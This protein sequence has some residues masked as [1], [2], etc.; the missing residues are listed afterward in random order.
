MQRFAGV[1]MRIE[2]VAF[3]SMATL[4][5]HGKKRNEQHDGSTIAIRSTMNKEGGMTETLTAA[6]VHELS[7]ALDPQHQG[8]QWPD[9]IAWDGRSLKEQ[10]EDLL[11]LADVA[12]DEQLLPANSRIDKAV[13]AIREVAA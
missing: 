13:E 1:L 12:I 4:E 2:L 9:P 5:R 10:A 7:E 11:V 3:W 6:M 8:E